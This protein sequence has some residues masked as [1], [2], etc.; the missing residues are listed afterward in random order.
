MGIAWPKKACS[1][2]C[3]YERH[4]NKNILGKKSFT[5]LIKP[6]VVV[7]QTDLQTSTRTGT[8]ERKF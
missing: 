6:R 5:G 1:L 3:Y 7:Q 4:E 2:F 8:R